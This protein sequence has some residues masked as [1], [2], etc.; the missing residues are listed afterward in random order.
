MV[1]M[2]EAFDA[3]DPSSPCPRRNTTT[4]AP[5]ALALMNDAFVIEQ[6]ARFA[7]RLLREAGS[8]PPRQVERAFLLALGR[9]PSP[10]ERAQ[11]LAFLD[12]QRNALAADSAAD[13]WRSA[14]TDFC[15]ALF[16]L[17]EFAYLD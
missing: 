8:S 5:Q 9:P 15:Q 2:L 4:V 12:H 7:E 3:A 10:A 16:N 14:L 11:A 1:P 6:A 17:N 13:P